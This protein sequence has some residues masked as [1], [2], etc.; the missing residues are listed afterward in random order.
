MCVL[1][2]RD[3]APFVFISNLITLHYNMERSPE[4]QSDLQNI[5]L[6][7]LIHPANREKE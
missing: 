6:T 2:L 1:C 4:P 3:F 7:I 5:R